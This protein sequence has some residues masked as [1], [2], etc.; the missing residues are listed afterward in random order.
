LRG[1][2]F[3]TPSVKVRAVRVGDPAVTWDEE[4]IVWGDQKTPL[5]D[6]ADHFIVDERVSDW[7]DFPTRSAHPT[8]NGAPLPAGLYEISVIVQSILSS[9]RISV[10][11][12]S[13]NAVP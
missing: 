9:G 1:F 4:C 10:V 2:N 5:K 6:E 7:V 12:E 8:L 3:I 13:I 11:S